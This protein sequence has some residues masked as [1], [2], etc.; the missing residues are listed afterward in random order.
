MDLCDTVQRELVQ[1]VRALKR[2]PAFTATT[3]LT[4][5]LALG[6][7]T[8]IFTILDAVVL[9]P[10]PYPHGER[11]VALS[12]PVP[13]VKA[14]P[15]WGLGRHEL[16]YFKRT[17]RTLEDLGLYNS[18]ALSVMGDGGSHDAERV[19]AANVSA[20]L[21]SVLGITPEIGRL[22]TTADNENAALTRS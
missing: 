16:R 6:A 2:T 20:S 10:L 4:L 8:A 21:F 19:M 17:S 12:S 5:A 7:A 9:R 3:T 14:A 15:V 18:Y 22:I 11:L 13:R 1:A